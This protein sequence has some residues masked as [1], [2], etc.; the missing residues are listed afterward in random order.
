MSDRG[1]S[2]DLNAALRS[3]TVRPFVLL[4]AEFDSGVVPLSTHPRSITF[5]GIEYVGAGPIMK[6]GLPPEV[7]EI[8]APGA[9]IQLNGLDSSIITIAENESFQGRPITAYLGAYDA[10]GAV[11]ADPDIIGGG[12]ID[13]I[14]EI[15]DGDRATVTVTIGSE[16]D[17]L[18]RPRERRYT[19]ED[20][21]LDFPDD[22]AMRFVAA[23]QDKEII[24]R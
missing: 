23:L 22:G 14:E 16:L 5:D 17:D 21:A 7:A 3:S 2:T 8:R 20:Q 1:I 24:W 11:I 10:S 4:K 18:E 15:E 9:S 12:F 19:P 6:L 13:Q